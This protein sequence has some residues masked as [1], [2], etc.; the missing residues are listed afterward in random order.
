MEI[1]D[2]ETFINRIP[3][4]ITEKN[5]TLI[6]QSNKTCVLYGADN[7]NRLDGIEYYNTHNF[8]GVIVNFVGDISIA[9][10]SDTNDTFGKDFLVL[11]RNFMKRKGYFLDIKGNDLIAN[12][13]YKVAS[14]MSQRFGDVL[15]TGIH[16]S[17]NVD[18]DIINQ[19]CTKEMVKIP[20]G[21]TNF[22]VTTEELLDFIQ[23]SLEDK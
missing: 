14:F 17:M 11:L 8:G 6:G 5:A 22:G 18:I 15:F 12:G 10:Y 20:K 23:K 19:I 7:F 21:L 4:L 3:T 9:N 16:I 2:F 13:V 1:I